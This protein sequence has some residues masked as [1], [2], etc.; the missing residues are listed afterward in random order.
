MMADAAALRKRLAELHEQLNPPEIAAA[1]EGLL[2]A[3]RRL[4]SVRGTNEEAAARD[5]RDERTQWLVALAAEHPVGVLEPQGIALRAEIR[6]V[7]LQLAQAEGRQYLVHLDLPWPGT[8]NEEHRL[9][10]EPDLSGSDEVFFQSTHGPPAIA[11]AATGWGPVHRYGTLLAI[12]PK[13]T[14]MPLWSVSQVRFGYPNE[15]AYAGE[16]FI[17]LGDLGARIFGTGFD[18]VGCFEVFNST[19][20]ADVIDANRHKFPATPDDLGLR[21]FVFSFKSNTLE[22]LAA[23]VELFE[24]PEG[25]MTEASRIYRHYN[26][27]ARAA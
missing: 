22:V 13:A 15:D 12:F 23:A 10:V 16:E 26:K 8:S 2:A 25:T 3:R 5:E 21:H 1:R 27:R 11:F 4:A 17:G 18:G 19:W 14:P 20:Q 7:E 9:R 6:S 24:V